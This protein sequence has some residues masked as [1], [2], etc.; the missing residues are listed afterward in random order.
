[1]VGVGWQRGYDDCDDGSCD[2]GDVCCGEGDVVLLM[3]WG[4]GDYLF[5]LDWSWVFVCLGAFNVV[6][7]LD[8][9]NRRNFLVYGYFLWEVN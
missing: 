3:G 6:Y 4:R 1:M 9:C 2:C 8:A 5:F 7:V